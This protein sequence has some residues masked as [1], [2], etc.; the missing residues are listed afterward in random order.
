MRYRGWQVWR[1]SVGQPLHPWENNVCEGLQASVRVMQYNVKE[2]E[3]GFCGLLAV[4]SSFS[5]LSSSFS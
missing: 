5:L 2:E 4:N 1:C 3:A